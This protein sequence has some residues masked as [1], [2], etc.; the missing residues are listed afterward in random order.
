MTRDFGG[1]RLRI[2]KQQREEILRLSTSGEPRMA[3]L[4][5][6]SLGLREEYRH[7]NE[8]HITGD[9]LDEPYRDG[10]ICYPAPRIPAFAT[11]PWGNGNVPCE[12]TAD[13]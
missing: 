12:P 4:Y 2:S 5:A 11:Q 6:M 3:Q 10:E 13:Y 1:K 7:V 9:V 8:W